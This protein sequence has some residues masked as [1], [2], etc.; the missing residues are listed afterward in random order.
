MRHPAP[1]VEPG[2]CYGRIDVA[3]HPDADVERMA[4]DPLLAGSKQVW[5]SP[6]RRCRQ[7]AGRIAAALDVPL[8]ADPRLMEL[9]FGDWEGK[10]WDD[11]PRAELD[12]WAT[13]PIDFRAPGGE[14][15][16]ELIA[17][18]TDFHARLTQDCV[19]VSHGGP[20]R[21]LAALLRG[22]AVDLFTPPQAIGAI[23]EIVISYT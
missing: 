22:E 12:R 7:L 1:L 23:V 13:D 11:L 14:S 6:S 20:L 19:V 3:L 17:R 16:A 21:V 5:T 18:I 10:P 8:S 4:S 2:I 9:D 15:G